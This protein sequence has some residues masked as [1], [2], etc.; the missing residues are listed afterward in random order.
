[1]IFYSGRSRPI[2]QDFVLSQYFLVTETMFHAYT[3]EET[4]KISYILI[5]NVSYRIGR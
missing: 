1:M 2:N 3:K 5:F 4:I